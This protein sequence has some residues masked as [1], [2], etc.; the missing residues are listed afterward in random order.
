MDIGKPLIAYGS[1]DIEDLRG[2]MLALPPAFWDMDAASRAKVAG[3]RPGR[4]VFLYNPMPPTVRRLML[5]EARANGTVSVLRY[6]DRPL[7]DD[8]RALID[9]QIQ[10]LFPDCDP[11]WA[12]L[13]ELPPGG[14]IEPHSDSHILAMVHRLHVPIVTHDKVTFMID[15]G[16]F[17]L[18]ADTL[19]DLN[20]V[21]VHAVTNESDVMRIH[22]LVDMMPHSIGR[23][24][25]FDDLAT[26]AAAVAPYTQPLEA[27]PLQAQPLKAMTPST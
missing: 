19:Y 23:A 17:H 21:A 11:I 3:G 16:A 6:P 25:Y 22:L 8:I 18:K 9:E 5:A 24:R 14:V 12:Q 7:F 20:N 4:A 15:E 26:M 27:Q 13:A 2:K 1:V 10:P